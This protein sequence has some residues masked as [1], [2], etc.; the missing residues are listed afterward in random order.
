MVVGPYRHRTDDVGGVNVKASTSLVLEV[1]IHSI[2]E[3]STNVT[4][5]G[6]SSR[7]FLA[8]GHKLFSSTLRNGNHHKVLPRERLIHVLHDVLHLHVNL[9]N[10]HQIHDRRGEGRVH[11]YKA[12]ISAHE[13]HDSNAF[14]AAGSFNPAITNHFGGSSHSRL[15]TKSLVE[16]KDIIVDRFRHSNDGQLHVPLSCLLVK[17]VGCCLCSV[18]TNCEQHVDTLLLKLVT[19]LCRIKAP[20]T[21]LQNAS[22]FHVDISDVFHSKLDWWVLLRVAQP[23]VA[24]LHTH[25]ATDAILVPEAIGHF[26]DDGI[27]TRTETTASHYGS[28]HLFRIEIDIFAS[29]RTDTALRN[30]FAAGCLLRV[31][32]NDVPCHKLVRVQEVHFGPSHSHGIQV[33]VC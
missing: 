5:N 7:V 29:I 20:S 9:R 18:A 31:I 24:S 19:D 13:L 6:V 21:S 33:F 12:G 28:F 4:I 15:E 25:D 11:C 8:C 14:R 23:V 16:K 10:H 32:E 26:S 22:T 3:V 17:N 27:E 30:L 2:L 1:R